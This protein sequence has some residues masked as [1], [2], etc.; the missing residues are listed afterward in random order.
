MF[1]PKYF[2]FHHPNIKNISGLIINILIFF[3]PFVVTV[4]VGTQTQCLHILTI[5][6]HA[7]SDQHH[8][9]QWGLCHWK[10]EGLASLPLLFTQLALFQLL[11]I[12]SYKSFFHLPPSYGLY[13]SVNN[14]DNFKGTLSCQFF[15]PYLK[16]ESYLN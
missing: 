11:L 3:K 7:A 10:D 15:Y 12:S 5:L 9:L 2:H 16:L 4:T 1:L 6:I 13:M 14:F 8:S